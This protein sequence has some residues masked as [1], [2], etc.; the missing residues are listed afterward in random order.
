L[1]ALQRLRDDPFPVGSEQDP[2]I[3]AAD[4]NQWAEVPGPGPP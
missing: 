4:Q 3:S 1:Q 2:R